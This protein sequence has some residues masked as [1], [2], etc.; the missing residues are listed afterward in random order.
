MR[1]APRDDR[2]IHLKFGYEH[3]LEMAQ[4]RKN[5]EAEGFSGPALHMEAARCYERRHKH[6]LPYRVRQQ[7]AKENGEAWAG[8][9]PPVPTEADILRAALEAIRDGHND[10][11]ALA[12]EVLAKVSQ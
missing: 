10:P 12:A 1:A 4:I 5:L 7:I 3:A 6:D 8:G 11:R 9:A 2:P